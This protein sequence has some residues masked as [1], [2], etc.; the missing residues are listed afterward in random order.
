M[1]LSIKETAGRNKTLL[2][3]KVEANYE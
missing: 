3:K 1:N 2:M